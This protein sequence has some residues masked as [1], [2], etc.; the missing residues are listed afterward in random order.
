MVAAIYKRSKTGEKAEMVM[1]PENPNTTEFQ[2][3]SRKEISVPRPYLGMSGIGS[4]CLAKLWYDFHWANYDEYIARVKR[5]FARGHLE[6]ARII[7][8][9]KSVGVEVFRLDRH[10]NKI[11]MTGDVDEKQEEIVGFAGHAKGH[12][13]GRCLR[14]IEAPKTEHLLEMKS[15]NEKYF[16][17]LLDKGLEE[18]FPVY[19]DQMQRYMDELKLKRG[20]FVATNKN[21]EA[22]KYIRIKED[23]EKQEELKKKEEIVILQEMPFPPQFKSD[24]YKCGWCKHYNTCHFKKAPEM[25]CRTCR[26]SDILDEGRWSCSL[27][28][29]KPLTVKMQLKGCDS[30]L[31]LF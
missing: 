2:I 4:E 23:K 13:D 27:H 12:P 31:R 9:L 29:D 8:D 1:I 16:K 24:F 20:F 10:G 14:I 30:Y 15:M 11:E 22:R 17:I 19:Y 6:E 21:T 5:I 3:E 25:N 7:T 26:Y 28:N 18:G